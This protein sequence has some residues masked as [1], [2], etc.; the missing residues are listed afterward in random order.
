MIRNVMAKQFSMK[1][2]LCSI[3]MASMLLGDWCLGQSGGGA[4][5]TFLD[6]SAP[7]RVAALGG[8]I[9]STRTDDIVL[10]TQNPALLNPEMDQQLSMSFVGYVAGIRYGNVL[11]AKDAARFGTF[12]F[13]MQY[14]SYGEFKQTSETSEEIGTFRAGEYAFNLAWSKTLDSTLFIGTN[15]KYITSSLGENTS[16]GIAA[17]IGLSWVSRDKNWS[18]ACVVKNAGRQLRTYQSRLQEDLPFQIQAG[19]SRQLPK[20]P[21]RFSLTAQQLQIWD[22]SYRDPSLNTIDPLTGE[23]VTEK[24]SFLDKA[25]LHL[26]AGVEVL[27]SKNFNIRAGYN[28][29]R[30]NELAFAERRGLSGMSFGLGFRINRFH[31]SYAYGLLNTAGGSNHFTV[32]TSMHDFK[33]RK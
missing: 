30:R 12:G 2:A 24:N 7:A 13:N 23:E 32:T 9:I 10:F 11:V 33:R 3:F 5:F 8:N 4:V 22:L 27:M 25:L 28:L 29:L 15:L 19:I 20:A 31:C 18:A 21:F 6:L 16:N 17:D 1:K 14:I 26:V